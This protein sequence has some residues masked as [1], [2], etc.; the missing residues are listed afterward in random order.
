[1]DKNDLLLRYFSGIA[2]VS[3]ELYRECYDRCDGICEVEGC[4]NRAE[5]L[6]HKVGRRR[7]AW[8]GNLIF[9][10]GK[11]HQGSQGVHGFGKGVE[12]N[13]KILR[14]LQDRYSEMGFTENEVRYLNGSKSNKLY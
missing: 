1:V 4:N 2:R 6:H 3:E 8:S 7:V 10:C 11:H 5:T 9:L 12:L 14:E 13:L